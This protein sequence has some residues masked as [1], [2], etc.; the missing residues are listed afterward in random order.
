VLINRFIQEIES[1]SISLPMTF[2]IIST[3]F[4]NFASCTAENNKYAELFASKFLFR[5]TTT[6]NLNTFFFCFGFTFEGFNYLQTM[7]KE[8]NMY[9]LLYHSITNSIKEMAPLFQY[10]AQEI[11][12]QFSFLLS[13]PLEPSIKNTAMMWDSLSDDFQIENEIFHFAKIKDFAK[14][15]NAFPATECGC[16]RVFSHMRN[17]IGD[18]RKSLSLNSIRNILRIRLDYLFNQEKNSMQTIANRLSRVNN[19]CDD[20]FLDY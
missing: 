19:D 1:N 3:L 16:E 20:E 4:A 15:L 18:E 7:N 11:L 2:P 8:L 12:D 17:I 10:D 5:F 14:R 9:S 6:E 13:N